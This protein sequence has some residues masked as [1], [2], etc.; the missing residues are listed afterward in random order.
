[1]LSHFHNWVKFLYVQ[2]TS[3]KDQAQYWSDHSKQYVFVPV[4]KFTEAFKQSKY[5]RSLD[6]SLSSPYEETKSLPSA[7]ASSK[8]ALTHL[9]LFKACTSREVLLIRRN[10]FLYIFKTCQVCF[11]VCSIQVFPLVLVNIFSSFF[12]ANDI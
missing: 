9:Q 3:K 10:S 7:L 12:W 6:S 11:V 2:V 5:G 1:M 4:P 8:F